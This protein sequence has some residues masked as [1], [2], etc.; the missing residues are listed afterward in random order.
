M[1]NILLSIIIIAWLYTTILWIN[2]IWPIVKRK[3]IET[4]Y[5]TELF[6]DVDLVHYEYYK[7]YPF[8]KW[9]LYEV[10]TLEQF[11]YECRRFRE[12]CHGDWKSYMNF[13]VDKTVYII[14]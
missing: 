7:K 2:D 1:N 4:H 9:Q 8:C 3:V 11:E 13:E 14:D 6:R 5:T 10:Q 12:L